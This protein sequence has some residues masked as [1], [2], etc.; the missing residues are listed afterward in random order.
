M[1]KN[2]AR[3][4][5]AVASPGPDTSSWAEGEWFGVSLRGVPG[6]GDYGACGVVVR[7][8]KPVTELLYRF[9]DVSLLSQQY[10]EATLSLWR[11]LIER[12]KRAM[13]AGDFTSP[14]PAMLVYSKPVPFRYPDSMTALER[15]WEHHVNFFRPPT[16]KTRAEG[17]HGD[18]AE[19]PVSR[20]LRDLRERHGELVA[21]TR[22]VPS[23][24]TTILHHA[25]RLVAVTAANDANIREQLQA[26]VVALAIQAGDRPAE[27]VIL[28]ERAA[29]LMLELSELL[30]V[31][32]ER[33]KVPARFE[34][35][36]HA[37]EELARFLRSG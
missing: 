20:V 25:G 23:D 27:L 24:D 36:R 29:D 18:N 19:L 15:L 17:G 6:S 5:A 10:N 2:F 12:G 8:S 16:H 3:R 9:A 31:L 35:P 37:A 1:R 4:L 32:K 34:Q 21:N 11:D 33:V 26:G 30:A 7:T 13:D 22:F 28:S 14:A